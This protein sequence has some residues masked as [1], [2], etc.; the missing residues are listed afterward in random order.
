ML[1]RTEIKAFR[2]PLDGSVGTHFLHQGTFSR[3]DVCS[4]QQCVLWQ[5]ALPPFIPPSPS[6]SLPL[7]FAFAPLSRCSQC[8]CVCVRQITQSEASNTSKKERW[9]EPGWIARFL[10]ARGKMTN[11]D[12]HHSPWWNSL[13]NMFWA[14][15]CSLLVIKLDIYAV[16]LFK[17]CV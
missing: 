5:H 10:E 2:R 12:D 7:S 13:G 4:A 15:S 6:L 17:H 9:F 8:I 1:K 3:M 16:S 14:E 11:T